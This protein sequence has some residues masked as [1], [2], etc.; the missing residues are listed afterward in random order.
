[1]LNAQTV[2]YHA[3]EYRYTFL[4]FCD[5]NSSRFSSPKTKSSVNKK[6]KK[7]Q[8]CPLDFPIPER[9]RMIMRFFFK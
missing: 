5:K 3:K 1:M 7:K 9:Y 2:F 8:N 6:L 4:G